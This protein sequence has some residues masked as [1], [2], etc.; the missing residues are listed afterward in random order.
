MLRIPCLSVTR[1]R[2]M[3]NILCSRS[4]LLLLQLLSFVATA[5]PLDVYHNSTLIIDEIPGRING[6]DDFPPG[7][8]VHY[9]QDGR[10]L[11][12]TNMLKM[13]Y[14]AARMADGSYWVSLI[15]ENALWRISTEGKTL[16]VIQVGGYPCAFEVL[17]NGNLLVAGWDDDVPGFV[18]EFTPGGELVWQLQD[19]KWPWKAQRLENGNT[20]I[21][22]AGLNRVYEV[23]QKGE[24]VWAVDGLGPASNELF[25][26]LGPVYVERLKNGH[27]L[28]SIRASSRVVELDRGGDIV[29][30]IGSEIVKTPYSAT[31][32]ANGNTLIAD[33]GNHRVIEVT[34]DKKIAWE[35]GGFGYPAK[36]YRQE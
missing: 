16:A 22:D 5:E 9:A 34:R 25:D 21:A 28:V 30:E 24:E 29:W 4:N 18:K 7:R 1:N 12:E 11:F 13:P 33:G 17:A 8:L 15:R 32:L 14:D 31:R 23:N 19:L 2:T 6:D 26:G 35:K 20:L 27:T 10:I 3:L 36:A